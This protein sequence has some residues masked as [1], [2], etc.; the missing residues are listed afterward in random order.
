[1]RIS[2]V[3]KLAGPLC[4]AVLLIAA[5]GGSDDSDSGYQDRPAPPASSFPATQGRSLAQLLE[6]E[7]TN[8][9]LVVTPTE[10]V[11]YKGENRFGFG[12]FTRSAKE[13]IGDAEIALYA[14]KAPPPGSAPQSSG[15]QGQ[16]GLEFALGGRARGPYPAKVLT[17]ETEAP[18]TAKTTADDPDS[19]KVVYTTD[20]DFPSNG[21]WRIAAMIRNGD[22]LEATLLPSAVVG[23]FTTI[24]RVGERPPAINTPTRESVGGNLE[25]LTTRIPPETMNDSDFAEV[26][27]KKPVA[28]LFA[29]PQFCESRVCGPVVD[30]AE[31]VK[32][33]Y[34]DQVEFIHMEIYND[35]DPGKGVRPQVR[36]FN[37]PS[38]PW[39]FVIDR[40][41]RISTEIEGAFGVGELT[42]AVKEVAGS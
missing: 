30:V 8:T 36:D 2:W 40:N 12:V 3:A 9:T 20:I 31:Q 16:A 10:R 32:E 4:L 27:G 18:F 11:F 6:D 13:Q 21:E 25:E 41:G 1:M 15:A 38:E 5:C 39:L 28:L 24:P 33:D 14:A 7:A 23:Q 34:E 37:L 17:L 19:G 42:E 35:N 29:T 26:L 22:E